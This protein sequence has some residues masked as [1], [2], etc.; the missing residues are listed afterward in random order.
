MS[1]ITL[2]QTF[3]DLYIDS[4]QPDI[5][6]NSSPV[7]WVGKQ[8]DG[9]L[10]RSLTKFDLSFIPIGSAILSSNLNLYM[11]YDASGT[12]QVTTITPY[13]ISDSWDVSTVTWNNQ[14]EINDVIT[15]TSADVSI[16]GYYSWTITNLIDQWVN[17]GLAN[18]GLELKTE[19]IDFEE[20]KR[21]VSSNENAPEKQAFKP[22]LVIQYN[23]VSPKPLSVNAVIAG[24][25]VDTEHEEITTG[26][27]FQSTVIR[28][29]SDRTLVSFFVNNLTANRAD[30][31]IEVSTDGVNYLRENYTSISQ[32][33]RIFIPSYYATYT[34]LFYKS[35]FAGNPTTLSIDYVAQ[36]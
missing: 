24:H 34:R 20:N 5:N 30:V 4:S 36:A 29:T 33:L 1:I 15:G 13:A 31:G 25:D 7:M 2:I 26:D 12:E 27:V 19:E 14:P 17:G 3:D 11:D 28:N 6:F 10:E 23:P 35:N 32:G 9:T 21:F 8:V 16:P 22:V 18:N